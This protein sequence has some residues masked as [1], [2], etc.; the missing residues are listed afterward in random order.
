MLLCILR[1]FREKIVLVYY[2]LTGNHESIALKTRAGI[3][4][5]NPGRQ[6]KLTAGTLNFGRN[7]GKNFWFGIFICFFL[8]LTHMFSHLVVSDLLDK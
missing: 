3:V 7:V 6:M 2:A 8:S 5:H 4:K 1:Q